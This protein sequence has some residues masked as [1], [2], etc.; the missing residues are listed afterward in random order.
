METDAINCVEAE[1]ASIN[2]KRT[3]VR[4]FLFSFFVHLK[5]W[6]QYERVSETENLF[7]ILKHFLLAVIQIFRYEE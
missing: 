3:N 2:L 5:M 1:I 7:C 6:R 4:F